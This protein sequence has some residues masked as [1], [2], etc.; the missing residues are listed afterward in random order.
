MPTKWSSSR[1]RCG[2][3]S[4]SEA[5]LTV[6]IGSMMGAITALGL[7]AALLG[8]FILTAL[9]VLAL[10]AYRLLSVN[11]IKGNGVVLAAWRPALGD[12]GTVI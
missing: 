12:H 7:A 6:G 11:A 1:G 3:L 9:V 4:L 5:V 10:I 2:C 8:P